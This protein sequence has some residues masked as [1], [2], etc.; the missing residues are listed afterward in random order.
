MNPGDNTIKELKKTKL[1]PNSMMVCFFNF[2]YIQ[3]YI[4]EILLDSRGA[5]IKNHPVVQCL[6][7]NTN[8]FGQHKSY[9]N[10]RMIQLTGVFVYCLGI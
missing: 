6:Q 5:Y 4:L 1:V 7:H 2:N 3:L 9:N 8:T 10:N